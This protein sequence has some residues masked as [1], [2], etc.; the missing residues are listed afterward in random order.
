MG[1]SK[2]L[3]A[4]DRVYNAF[5]RRRFPEL[6][7]LPKENTGGNATQSVTAYR[8]THLTTSGARKLVSRLPR[9]MKSGGAAG[10]NLDGFQ[11][12]YLANGDNLSFFGEVNRRN[13]DRLAAIGIPPATET[14]I[15]DAPILALRRVSLGLLLEGRP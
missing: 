5:Y 7:R 11:R 3:R 8:L 10:G 1:L 2:K 15:S 13:R 14:E 6:A 12:S 4:G 9:W